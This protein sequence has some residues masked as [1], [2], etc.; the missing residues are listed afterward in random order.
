MIELEKELE[1]HTPGVALAAKR[2]PPRVVLV[3]ARCRVSAT[4]ASDTSHLTPDTSITFRPLTDDDLPLLHA[5]L[6]NPDVARWC[7]SASRTR[8]TPRWSR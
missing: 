8:R 5:W 6:N 1:E 7:T 2:S 3:D 4:S